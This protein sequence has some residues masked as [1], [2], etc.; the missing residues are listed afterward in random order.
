MAHQKLGGIMFYDDIERRLLKEADDTRSEER[1]RLLREA[2]DVIHRLRADLI[3]RI[4]RS[5]KRPN[6][7]VTPGHY[8]RPAEIAIR[9]PSATA[10]LVFPANRNTYHNAGN[11]HRPSSDFESDL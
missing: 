6:P 9:A 1:E 2:A 4:Q 3:D 11:S 5:E 7:L 10:R 8:P